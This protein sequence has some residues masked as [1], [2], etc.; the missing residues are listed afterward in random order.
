MVSWL[1]LLH[2]SENESTMFSSTSFLGKIDLDL[3]VQKSGPV[4]QCFLLYSS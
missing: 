3:K 2:N 1:Y 4:N